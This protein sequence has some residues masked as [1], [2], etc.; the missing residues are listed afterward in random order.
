MFRV[1]CPS[2]P[3]PVFLLA[4]RNLGNPSVHDDDAR[5][6]ASI[7]EATMEALKTVEETGFAEVRM[8]L[9]AAGAA[10]SDEP[11]FCLI[12]QLSGIRG[13]LTTPPQ[14]RTAVSD[15]TINILDEDVWS[16]VAQGRLPAFDLLTSGFARVLV[17]V[18]D[19]NG[20]AEEFALSMPHG[21]T[22]GDVLK[23]YRIDG[24]DIV[25]EARPLPWRSSDLMRTV[26]VFPGMVVEVRP[27]EKT[28]NASATDPSDRV[29]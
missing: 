24:S 25:V 1:T 17:R 3:E 12:A 8:G 6:L 15:I 26:P 19:R 2:G 29:M 4:A 5:D 7:T 21:S 10:R 18:F 23:A 20:A 22:I 9:L 27:G 11:P 13:F 14:G 16:V 28:V